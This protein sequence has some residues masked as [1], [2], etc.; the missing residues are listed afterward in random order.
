M[1]HWMQIHNNSIC[2]T[3]RFV[4]KRWLARVLFL[5]FILGI[6]ANS[7]F[8]M[9]DIQSGHPMWLQIQ[10]FL[11]LYL[12]RKS[13]KIQVNISSHFYY[14]WHWCH[15]HSSC[16]RNTLG[17]NKGVGRCFTSERDG[18]RIC[19]ESKIERSYLA[20]CVVHYD[21]RHFPGAGINSG[22]M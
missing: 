14:C 11:L 3:S 13:S 18:M 9:I 16:Y 19:G 12:L 7:I 5:W 6:M 22:F 10:S 17:K 2:A 1:I 21:N 15:K 8:A 4:F 20:S